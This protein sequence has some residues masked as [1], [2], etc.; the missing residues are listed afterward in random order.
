MLSPNQHNVATRCCSYLPRERC[1]E[2]VNR[3]DKYT[4]VFNVTWK[5]LSQNK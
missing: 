3:I 5:G 2:H 1:V 4:T